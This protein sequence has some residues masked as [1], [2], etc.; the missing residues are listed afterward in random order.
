MKDFWANL[1]SPAWWLSVVVVGLTTGVLAIYF[2]DAIDRARSHLSARQRALNAQALLDRERRLTELKADPH[3]QVMEGFAEQRN[4]IAWLQGVAVATLLA[5]SGFLMDSLG[6]RVAYWALA[7][8]TF[9]IAASSLMKAEEI[10][11]LNNEAA[12]KRP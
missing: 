2:K 8:F 6:F 11:K 1:S 7:A 9:L 5:F 4:R 10:K 3:L 12:A